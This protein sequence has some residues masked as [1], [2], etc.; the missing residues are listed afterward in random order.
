M[1]CSNLNR[2]DKPISIS[3]E[4]IHICQNCDAIFQKG[5]K[6][7]KDIIIKCCNRQNINKKSNIQY[8]NSCLTICIHKV[9]L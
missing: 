9:Y 8:C 3:F 5:T 2:C 7:V 6:Y 1:K 4:N